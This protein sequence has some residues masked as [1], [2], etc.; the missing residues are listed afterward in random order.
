MLR[1]AEEASL[2]A[3]LRMKKNTMKYRHSE[4]RQCHVMHRDCG[5]RALYRAG[6]RGQWDKIPGQPY[7]AKAVAVALNLSESPQAPDH[8]IKVCLLFV[9]GVA[10]GEKA[11]VG[12]HDLGGVFE[13][14]PQP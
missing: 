3:I 5:G 8:W 7:Q 14:R 2:V 4:S 10:K 12:K 6:I 9:R 1:T 11:Q 13:Y